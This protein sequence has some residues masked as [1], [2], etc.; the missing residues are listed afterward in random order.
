MKNIKLSVSVL[1][2]VIILLAGCSSVPSDRAAY[3]NSQAN[4]YPYC[5]E[6][7]NDVTDSSNSSYRLY[8][9]LQ[10]TCETVILHVKIYDDSLFT[11]MVNVTVNGVNYKKRMF[12]GESVKY[13]FNAYNGDV[14]YNVNIKQKYCYDD[15][16]QDF[17]CFDL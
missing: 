7:V 6:D 4:P 12:A 10:Y 5:G 2:A 1:I 11:Y 8:Y 15:E 3:L 14:N 17:I 13:Y 16:N 9:T